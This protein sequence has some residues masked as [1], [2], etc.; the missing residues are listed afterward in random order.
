MHDLTDR[1]LNFTKLKKMNLIKCQK[2]VLS[3]QKKR[4]VK[5]WI[6]QFNKILKEV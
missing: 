3:F 2:K 5:I 4:S 1:I 6:K